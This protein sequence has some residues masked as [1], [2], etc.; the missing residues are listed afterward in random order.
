MPWAQQLIIVF[1]QT[2][3]GTYS[4]VLEQVTSSLEALKEECH[5][6]ASNS[7]NLIRSALD[8]IMSSLTFLEEKIRGETVKPLRLHQSNCRT[9][10]ETSDADIDFYRN[11]RFCFLLLQ[12]SSTLLD[13]YWYPIYLYRL[14]LISNL[15]IFTITGIQFTN[16]EIYS[17]PLT[18]TNNHWPITSIRSSTLNDE[19]FT[20]LTF[21]DIQSNNIDFSDY[22]I[23]KNGVLPISSLLILIFTNIQRLTL[24]NIQYPKTHFY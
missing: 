13:F 6:K 3:Q 15:Q 10:L 4:L 22:S 5:Q 9:L 19:Q 18:I 2:M 20:I 23:S 14:L 16:F 12:I 1:V 17:F 11:P 7:Q 8:Q 21:T 24:A